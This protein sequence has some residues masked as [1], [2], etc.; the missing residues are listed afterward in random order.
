[1]FFIRSI[2]RLIN[3][4]LF[5]VLKAW[6]EGS[7]H[8]FELLPVRS[9]SLIWQVR[10]VVTQLDLL[11]EILTQRFRVNTLIALLIYLHYKVNTTWYLIRRPLLA[12]IDGCNWVESWFSWVR[13]LRLICLLCRDEYLKLLACGTFDNICK[14]NPKFYTGCLYGMFRWCWYLRCLRKYTTFVFSHNHM[15]ESFE[16]PYSTDPSTYA[17][18]QNALHWDELI[19]RYLTGGRDTSVMSLFFTALYK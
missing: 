19:I 16:T 12:L 10:N 5:P 4:F 15:S 7:C 3:V 2:K 14:W 1:M 11:V 17:L 9:R 18:E 13:F 6:T 8:P